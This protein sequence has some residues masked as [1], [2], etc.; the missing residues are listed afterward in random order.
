LIHDRWRLW[1]DDHGR[2]RRFI[3]DRRRVLTLIAV[4]LAPFAALMLVPPLMFTLFVSAPTPA[5][6]ICAGWVRAHSA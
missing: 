5:I 1:C 2:R 4:M 3:D 6:L